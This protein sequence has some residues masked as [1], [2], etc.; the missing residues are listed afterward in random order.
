[1]NQ[2]ET[3]G[4]INTALTIAGH[5]VSASQIKLVLSAFEYVACAELAQGR[6]VTLLDMGKFCIAERAAR[7]GRNPATGETIQIHAKRVVT[8]K[9]AKK[10]R[11]LFSV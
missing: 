1:M 10:L 7:S 3:I 9:A 8:F 6:E 4:A 11:Y 2:K 5:S